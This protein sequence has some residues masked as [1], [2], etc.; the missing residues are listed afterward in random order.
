MRQSVLDLL[1]VARRPM[2][3]YELIGRL[4]EARGCQV[5]PPTV[6]RALNYLVGAGIV[7][8]INS[9]NAYC[10]AGDRAR[11]SRLFLICDTCGQATEVIDHHLQ[12]RLTADARRLCFAIDRGSLELVGT[13]G[14]CQSSRSSIL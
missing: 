9:L 7:A 6:Y 8:Q 3:A 10:V 13:C 14:D 5:S 4:S 12:R 1:Q 11:R 2:R